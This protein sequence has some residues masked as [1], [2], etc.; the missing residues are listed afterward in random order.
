[1]M[2]YPLQAVIL[3]GGRGS[4][5]RPLTNTLPK[6]M[7]PVNGRPFLEYLLRQLEGQGVSQFLLLTGY[8]ADCIEDYFGDGSRWGWSI[9]YSRGPAEWDTGRRI[10]E[11][12]EK[13]GRRFIMLYSDNFVQ[14][15]FHRLRSLHESR[16]SPISLLLSPKD[17]GNIKFL[18]GAVCAYDKSRTGD[19]LDFVEVGYMLVNRDEMLDDLKKIAGFPNIS[20]S[21]LLERY[22][23]SGR[24]SGLVVKDAYHSVSDPVRLELTARYLAPK[25]IILIDRDGTINKKAAPGEYITT[26]ENFEWRMDTRLAMG[27]LAKLGFEFIVI[28]NQAGIARGLVSEEAVA[29]IH[30]RMVGELAADGIKVRDVYMSP[31]HWN[32]DSFQRKPAPG[33]FFKAS[34]EHLIRLDHCLYIGD[35]ERDCI[36]AANAGCGMVYLTDETTAPSIPEM[37]SPYLTAGSVMTVTGK[38]VAQY[39]AWERES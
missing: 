38:I 10:Y 15:N 39:Q 13:I 1:M 18:D 31:H 36:A 24:L 4:R 34:K 11:A 25:R 23:G 6:P 30:V 12:R 33:M 5:L 29:D 26:W 27:K 37:P 16:K 17:R 2:S 32:D 35:D 9:A 14:F 8:L 7:A 22:A 20:F 21:N 3:C 19:G 28:T